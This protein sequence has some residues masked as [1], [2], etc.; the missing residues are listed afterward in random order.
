MVIAFNIRPTLGVGRRARFSKTAR[1]HPAHRE[2]R[3]GRG[4]VRALAVIGRRLAHDVAERA[5]EGAQAAEADVETDVGHAA[6]GLAQ[7]EHRAFDAAA[8]QVAMWCLAERR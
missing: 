4:D 5:T 2:A 6:L 7:Q 3:G 1:S 8:L